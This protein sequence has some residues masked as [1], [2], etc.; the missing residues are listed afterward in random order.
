MIE[1]L[2]TD[3]N[4]YSSYLVDQVILDKLQ[5][6]LQDVLLSS[7]DVQQISNSFD[8]HL[9]DEEAMNTVIGAINKI[10]TSAT[11]IPL[12]LFT[13]IMHQRFKKHTFL[14]QLWNYYSNFI[15]KR[16]LLNQR[17]IFYFLG[18]YQNSAL[19]VVDVENVSVLQSF[20]VLFYLMRPKLFFIIWRWKRQMM[21]TWKWN[22]QTMSLLSYFNWCQCFSRHVAIILNRMRALKSQCKQC[23]MS[24][25]KL[26]V[27]DVWVKRVDQGNFLFV[28]RLKLI[29]ELQRT[30]ND[31][32][33]YQA[34]YHYFKS[35][36]KI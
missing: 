8:R 17:N 35:Y 28:K 20:S 3:I 31:R 2:Q 25:A 36:L 13:S 9:K 5:N 22:H 33:I 16:F 26:S 23:Q 7:L 32:D 11:T 29:W 24:I 21:I 14:N 10:A 1:F 6:F 30:R 18:I 27:I 12:S 34:L 19:N 4:Q 15:F